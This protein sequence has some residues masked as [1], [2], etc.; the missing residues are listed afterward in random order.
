MYAS[1]RPTSGVRRALSGIAAA[2]IAAAAFAPA[3]AMATMDPD[4]PVVHGA[5]FVGSTLTVEIEQGSF[6]GCGAAAG[7][8]YSIYW[9]R[10]GVL[11]SRQWPNYVVT[12]AD[13]GATIAA[14]LVASQNG[15]DPVEVSSEETAPVSASHRANGF[16]GRSAFELL[17][18]R[19]DGTLMMYPRINSAWESARTVGPGWNGFTTVLS[20]GDFNGDGTND[21][22]ARDSSGRL[23][24][25]EGTGDGGFRAGRQ[26]G[27]GWN[28]F[29]AIVSPGD[30]NGDGNNDV[31]A[32]DSSGNLYLYPG[33]GNGGWLNRSL[34]GTGW[35]V[36]NQI[37]TP[38][39]F[40]GD[41]N[42]DVLARDTSGNLRL[43][44]GNG[45]GGW[46]GSATI[47]WGWGS[48]SNIAAAGDVDG[49]GNMDVFAVDSSGQL[50]AYYGDGDGGW[51]GSGAIGWGWGGFNAVF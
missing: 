4:Q 18:R 24:L 28:G 37:I 33:N 48:L 7:P 25:Y 23:F 36:L 10:D 21:V 13:R 6:S 38:G 3:P 1:S 17:A 26:I 19:S 16:T 32:R 47:G 2:F 20:P 46:S 29:T 41:N 35:N 40:N 49:N 30:F 39:D 51:N 22:L 42:V 34:V 8:D 14:H 15:C 43:Y 9:T 12:E 45:N 31:L 44:K 27:S 11:S 50:L 5:P